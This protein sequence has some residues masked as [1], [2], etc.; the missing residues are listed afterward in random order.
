MVGSTRASQVA[1]SAAP[2]C[3]LAHALIARHATFPAPTARLAAT[4]H[5]TVVYPALQ[6][7]RRS[8]QVFQTSSWLVTALAAL[9]RDT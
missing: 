3:V 4:P 6:R 1:S 7:Q 8:M 9:G 5:A 2:A